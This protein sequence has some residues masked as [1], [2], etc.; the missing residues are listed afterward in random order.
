[1]AIGLLLWILSLLTSEQVCLIPTIYIFWVWPIIYV[2]HKNDAASRY[3]INKKE[4][5][6]YQ[7]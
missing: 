4:V 1:M 2:V 5:D 3:Q 6:T 7:E